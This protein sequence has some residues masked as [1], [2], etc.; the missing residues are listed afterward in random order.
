[1]Q[2]GGATNNGGKCC[3]FVLHEGKAEG[4]SHWPPPTQ[5]I[6]A[7]VSFFRHAG[8]AGGGV[9]AGSR[10]WFEEWNVWVWSLHQ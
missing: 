6:L 3:F 4:V 8:R 10:R 1:M 2:G 5:I 7:K 9:A